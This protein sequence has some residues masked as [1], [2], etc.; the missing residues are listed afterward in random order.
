MSEAVSIS[1]AKT[2]LSKL[3]A[4][5]ERGEEVTI[6]RGSTPV[7]KLVAITPSSSPQRSPIGALRGQIWIS[8]DFDG[9]GPEWDPYV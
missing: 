6:R 7:V 2:Q 3:V 4:R 8:D 1:E 5:A 9:M